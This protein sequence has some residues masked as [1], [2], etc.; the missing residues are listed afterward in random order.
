MCGRYSVSTPAHLLHEVFDLVEPPELEARWN[1]APTQLA[2]VVR[3]TA[4][5]RRLA[6]LRFG[7]VPAHSAGPGDGPLLVNARSETA[8]TLPAF[9]DSLRERRCLVPADG[10][11]EWRQLGR[12]RQPFHVR[13]PDGRPFAMAGLWSRWLGAGEPLESFAILTCEP[14]AALRP[15]HDRMPVILPEEAWESW[16][17]GELSPRRLQQLL[18]PYEGELAIVP[19]SPFVNKADHEGPECVRE[20]ALPPPEPPA[21]TQRSLF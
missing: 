13:R 2:P 21:A 17:A 1:V 10:F 20:V 3:R 18:V 6:N 4:E 14:T 5:G 19:V 11:Y 15:L 12:G 8:A 9:R 7:L 16:L